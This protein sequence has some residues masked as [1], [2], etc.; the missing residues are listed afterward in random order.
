MPNVVRSL[1]ATGC[2]T[3]TGVRACF[4][5]GSRELGNFAGLN[6]PA[7]GR[8]ADP[9]ETSI[10]DYLRAAAAS[11]R[12]AGSDVSLG[13]LDSIRSSAVLRSSGT[14]ASCESP[15]VKSSNRRRA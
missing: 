5:G 7:Q 11:R 15:T 12:K 3:M 8:I 6:K 1:H 2:G 13:A 10:V 4:G 14:T 9:Y